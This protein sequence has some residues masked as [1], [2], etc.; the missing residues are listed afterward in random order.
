MSSGTQGGNGTIITTG[1]KIIQSDDFYQHASILHPIVVGSIAVICL[2]VYLRLGSNRSVAPITI[3]DWLINV[4][5]GSTLAGIVNGNSLVRGL[6]GLLTM[7][8]FQFITSFLSS[9]K[10]GRGRLGQLFTSPPLVV[11]FRGRM[12]EKV[13]ESHRISQTDLHGALRQKGVLNISQVECI[14][15]EPTGTFSIFTTSQMK[16]DVEPEVLFNVPAYLALYEDSEAK[17]DGSSGDER[18]KK[19]RKANS[20]SSQRKNSGACDDEQN[21]IAGDE[22]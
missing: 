16:E 21:E 6:L 4:A 15:I 19:N 14:I 2:F 12:L 10:G 1:P 18:G 20:S 9:R 17:K 22:C 3:F 8:S 13:M 11:A 5:L 7:L